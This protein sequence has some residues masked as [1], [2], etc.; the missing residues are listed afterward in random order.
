MI[1]YLYSRSGNR[2]RRVYTDPRK[3]GEVIHGNYRSNE[4]HPVVQPYRFPGFHLAST[5]F[6]RPALPLV[7][8]LERRPD[9]RLPYAFANHSLSSGCH[10]ILLAAR[11]CP[12]VFVGALGLTVSSPSFPDAGHPLSGQDFISA[13][14]CAWTY[15]SYFGPVACNLVYE[16]Y[17]S[18]DLRGIRICCCPCVLRR[19]TFCCLAGRFGNA[20]RG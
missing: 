15:E 10:R 18:R 16:V 20:G 1:C 8:A 11:W 17:R 12:N 3:S 13:L 2:H 14:Y 5:V 6:D 4:I 19:G 7:P 9:T